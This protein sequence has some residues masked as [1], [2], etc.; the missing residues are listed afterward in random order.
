MQKQKSIKGLRNNRSPALRL[1][2]WLFPI[3][4]KDYMEQKKEIYE[5]DREFNEDFKSINELIDGKRQRS[6][7]R[8]IP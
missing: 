7:K 3:S 4:K 5:I 8:F 1:L 2:H 6:R